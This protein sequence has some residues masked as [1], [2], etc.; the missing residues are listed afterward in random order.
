MSLA[1]QLNLGARLA[2]AA[3]LHLYMYF[4]AC[5]NEFSQSPGMSP[6]W[7]TCPSF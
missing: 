4:D 2:W 6:L 7:D 5:T 1:L 3:Q